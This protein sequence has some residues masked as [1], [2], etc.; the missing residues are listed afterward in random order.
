MSLPRL[1]LNGIARGV[2][3]AP[4]SLAGDYYTSEAWPPVMKGTL[5][6]QEPSSA[7][8]VYELKCQPSKADIVIDGNNYTL[9]P[10][11]G[12]NG[13]DVFTYTVTQ[14]RWDDSTQTMIP[15]EG[16]T[17]ETNQVSLTILPVNQPPVPTSDT[18]L[19]VVISSTLDSNK[20][21]PASGVD[22]DGHKVTYR[23]V[24][25]PQ[26]GTFRFV[27]G[28]NTTATGDST[29]VYTSGNVAVRG[30]GG[31]SPCPLIDSPTV[32]VCEPPPPIASTR[33]VPTSL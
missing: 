23:L 17:P 27:A 19:A 21:E 16:T 25:T 4:A 11:Q 30:G 1:S 20:M 18:Q 33:R 12:E 26:Y 13:P 5:R 6:T 8:L 15:V 7:V 28:D 9:W 2:P 29:Y 14:T 3:S 31:P 22:V 32:A 10:R 24:S